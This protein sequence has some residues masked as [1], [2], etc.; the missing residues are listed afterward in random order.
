MK[1]LL[2][3]LGWTVADLII[4]GIIAASAVALGV[5]FAVKP[6]RKDAQDGGEAEGYTAEMVKR[7]LDLEDMGYPILHDIRAKD[8]K[9]G[10]IRIDQAMRLPASLLL[11]VSAPADIDGLVRCNAN[12]GEWRYKR[13]DGSVGSFV[14][15]LVR[16]H[17]LI[18]AMR[19]RFPLLKVRLLCVFPMTA[20]FAVKPPKLCCLAAN[21]IATVREMTAE[22]G[23]ASPIMDQ[24]WPGL[25]ALFTHISK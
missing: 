24:A 22:D 15:P 13:R 16:L 2:D 11:V 17:P 23:T 1:F 20:E 4:F 9:G 10:L 6:R 8:G 5:A 3:S 21:T 14:N 19:T 7:R 25:S 18:T 12:V